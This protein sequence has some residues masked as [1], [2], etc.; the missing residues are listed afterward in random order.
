MQSNAKINRHLQ[1]GKRL[2]DP[3]DDAGQASTLSRA[4]LKLKS[5]INT[6]ANLQNS[7]SFLQVQHGYLKSTGTILSRMSELKTTTLSPTIDSSSKAMIEEEFKE[8]QN[9]LR[10]IS[11]SKWN[12][13]SIFADQETKVLFGKAVDIATLRQDTRGSSGGNTHN[14]TRWG[15]YDGLSTVLKAGDPMPTKA[16]D[17]SKSKFLA[18]TITDE[19]RSNESYR[20]YYGGT[21]PGAVRYNNDLANWK[22][23]VDDN[24]IDAKIAAV[25]VQ[26]SA[27]HDPSYGGPKDGGALLPRTLDE[28]TDM[29]DFAKSYRGMVRESGGQDPYTD[30]AAIDFLK[31]AFMDITNGAKELPD[32][33]GFF[34][35][36]SGST[37][38]RQVNQAI[39]GFKK[40]VEDNYGVAMGG[41][42]TT[43]SKS[44]ARYAS[45]PEG[46]TAPSGRGRTGWVNG[47][48]L[49][50][51]EDWIEQSRGALEDM[52]TNDPDIS[53]AVGPGSIDKTLYVKS[54]VDPV[55]SI[56]DFSQENFQDFMNQL[57][58]AIGLNGAEQN[59]VQ[60][61]IEDLQTKQ[62][63]LEQAIETADGLDYSLAMTCYSRTRDQLHLTAN[64][65]STASDM[66]NVLYTDFLG[67]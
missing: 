60:S 4:N 12:G 20:A 66:E 1:T 43:S 48:W 49:A 41:P 29:P 24:H 30:A 53:E 11:L 28:S 47:V 38:F 42:I 6:Q 10:E 15:I 55:Y 16:K 65:V 44:D 51:Y 59:R 57:S 27:S 14:I 8:L 13:I 58:S 5:N 18:F 50:G 52:I 7:M 2:I 19:S 62:V 39:L 17:S 46:E 36:N 45:D 61:E 9:E 35:D 32:A 31:D 25:V 22:S 54:V 33:M 26:Q 21:H 67:D 23:F 37:M 63:G 40:W 34:V 64:L 3:Y 56:D